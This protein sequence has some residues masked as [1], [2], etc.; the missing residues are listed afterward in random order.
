M[1]RRVEQTLKQIALVGAGGAAGAIGR[2]SIAE[3]LDRP[4]GGFPWAT[5]LVNL[6]GCLAIGAASRRWRPGSDRWTFGVTGVLGGFTT[7]S[8][9][10]NETRELLADGRAPV[11]L[12][13]VAAT[14]L[15]GITAVA[16]A[17]AGVP[18]ATAPEAS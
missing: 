17:R 7:F 15:G 1:E 18:H 13:L 5:L 6:V 11:A 2:W 4:P 10:A 12:L 16:L 3:L 9:F 14:L 8:A